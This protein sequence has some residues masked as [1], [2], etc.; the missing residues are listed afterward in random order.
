MGSQTPPTSQ[1]GW[2]PPWA[3]AVVLLSLLGLV[4]L[5]LP[6]A[7]RR[8]EPRAVAAGAPVTEVHAVIGGPVHSIVLPEAW[9]AIPE[10]PNREEFQAL[11]RLCHSP[12]LVL[13]QPRLSEK[14]WAAVVRKMV[15][16]YGAPIPPEQEQDIVGYLIAVRGTE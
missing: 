3:G 5:T 1:P 13:T 15:A 2:G 10:G 12:R 11:C 4:C 7:S 8:D 9:P 6:S 16:V 14:Q